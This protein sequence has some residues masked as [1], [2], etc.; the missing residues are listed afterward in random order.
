MR[1]LILSAALAASF[2]AA[3]FAASAD[4]A[5]SAPDSKVAFGSVKKDAVGEAHHFTGLTGTVGADGA[6]RVEIDLATAET[7]IDIRNERMAEHVFKGLGPAVL[8]ATVDVAALEA[9]KPGETTTSDIEGVLTFGPAKIDIEAS[10]FLARLSETRALVTTDEMIWIGTEEIGVTAGI[11]KLMELA[12]LPSITRAV[13]V[14]FRLV[15]DE[16]EATAAAPAAAAD[17]ATAE[18]A[19][20]ETAAAA[21]DPAA[22][23]KVFRKCK[24]CHV[25]DEAKNKVG[26]HLVGVIGRKAASVDG[27]KYSKS[28]KALDES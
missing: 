10:V 19:P 12:E 26:P 14:T 28:F 11:D 8:T 5:L 1:G 7:W 17:T 27:F 16:T 20:V 6:A 25:A 13:P 3:P 24:A 18:A 2:A 23:A 9:L 22:G 21:G 15:F 4:W